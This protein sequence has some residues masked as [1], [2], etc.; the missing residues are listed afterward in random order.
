MEKIKL[1]LSDHLERMTTRPKDF[2]RSKV[3]LTYID[4]VEILNGLTK[5][6]DQEC[7]I[8]SFDFI[9]PIKKHYNVMGKDGNFR[10][11]GN[12]FCCA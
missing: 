8:E 2:K 9:T 3:K 7:I 11:I 10:E 1:R 12:M 6:G 5:L 4:R